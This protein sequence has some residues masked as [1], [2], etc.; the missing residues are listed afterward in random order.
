MKSFGGGFPRQ[1]SILVFCVLDLRE[2]DHSQECRGMHSHSDG[3]KRCFGK[4]ENAVHSAGQL[5]WLG[6]GRGIS[7]LAPAPGDVGRAQCGAT[8]ASF[9]S[10]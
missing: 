9:S 8:G 5:E 2:G 10:V 4:E 6:A 7:P 1:K 3:H